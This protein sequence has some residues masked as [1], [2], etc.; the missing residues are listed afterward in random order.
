[1]AREETG[2]RISV[3]DNGAGI[4]PDAPSCG[5]GLG[6]ANVRERLRTR[7]GPDARLELGEVQ[8]HGFCATLHLPLETHPGAQT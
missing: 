8:P 5:S 4:Q 1:V 6:L 2:L 7:Y 3:S